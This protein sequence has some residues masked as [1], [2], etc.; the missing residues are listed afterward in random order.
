MVLWRVRTRIAVPGTLFWSFIVAFSLVRIPLD[1]T[2]AYE[3]GSVL[4]HVGRLEITESQIV[5]LALAL[6]ATL[7]IL[8]L[9]RQATPVAPA[10]PATEAAPQAPPEAPPA[11]TLES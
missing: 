4:G 7:M 10:L 9:R 2:R 5:S 1:F 11:A 8:R 3:P 6:F